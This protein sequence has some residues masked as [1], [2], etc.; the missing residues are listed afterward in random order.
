MDY[1]RKLTSALLILA[2]VLSML[3]TGMLSPTAHAA[4]DMT[5]SVTGQHT[6][7]LYED[8]TS[9]TVVVPP[10]LFS[11][12]P[13]ADA[14]YLTSLEEMGAVL[15]DAMEARDDAPVIYFTSQRV[16]DDKEKLT[17]F[18][19]D[20]LL[21]I[22]FAHTGVSTE[23]DYLRWQ[24]QNMGFGLSGKYKD[25]A[26][27]YTLTFSITYYTTAEQ[28]QTVTAEI[29][30]LLNQLDVDDASDYRK[31]CAIYDYIC[32]NV[33]YDHANL[34]NN[35]Y[36]LK[37]TCYAALI[38]GIAVCQGYALLLYRLA[39]ELDVDA[40]LIAGD[41]GGPH[42]WNI[43]QLNGLYYNLDST[44]DAGATKYDYFLVCPNNFRDHIRYE[45]YDTAE[46]H[47]AYPMDSKDFDPANDVCNHKYSSAIAQEATCTETGVATY[48]CSRCGDSYTETVAALGHEEVTDE[49]F[50]ATCTED[51]LTEGSH[52]GRCDI[53]L[54]EQETIP[55]LGH[56]EVTDKG[57]DATCTEDGRTD[58]SHCSRCDIV[59]TEQKAI[60]A[61]GHSWDEGTVTREPT[62]TEA[63]IRTFTCETCGE[64]REETIPT[65]EHEH[66][67]TAVV[68][69]PTC[70]E[71]GFTTYTCACGDS[72][73]ADEVPALG[74]EEV[75]DK[76]FDA[77][78][79]EDGMTDGSHCSRCDIVLTEQET[80]PALGH[81]WDEGT[82]IREPTETE[83]GIRT[84]TCETCGETKTEEIPCIDAPNVERIAGHD[85]VETAI[86]TAN[87]LKETLN[88][89]AFDTII[90]A[91][92]D[93]F[94]DALAGSYLATVKDAP[95]LLHR[96][97][98]VGDELN[99]DYILN[100][101]TEGGVVYVLGGTAAI[102]ASLVTDLTD[103]GIQ[104]IRLFGDSRFLTNLAILE[105]AGVENQE[106]LITTGWEFADCLSASATGKPI[107][108]LNTVTNE[109][110]AEQVE[111]L[112]KYAANNY[113]I[114][115]G[116]AAVSDELEA[117]IDEIVTGEIV[118][119][120][121]SSREETSVLVAERFFN[122]PKFAVLA[123]SRNFPDGL[124][125]G[126]L[127]YA[128]N[129]P[130]LLTNTGMEEVTAAY[131]AE[132]EIQAGYIMGG[133]GVVSDASVE[134]IFG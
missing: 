131:I 43:A 95:I 103:T 104:V 55:A 92:G 99:Q 85:R 129:A 34:D 109:L 87:A 133:T 37:Y 75:A 112:T 19:V 20:E 26:Y 117:A 53:V 17:S 94:A 121:G 124:C 44:W 31:L 101:L 80:I 54:T 105:E 113:T 66:S 68:T 106:I 4:D 21:P 70:T 126:P 59:L 48:T 13:A 36:T 7:P 81:T 24:Y 42:G 41:G 18:V 125:G 58:G 98:G 108:M 11:A 10:V 46:F 83:T 72:Y 111:F 30:K 100:N 65:L 64:T 128:M 88:K 115:G 77:T 73:T 39:L 51:G 52:C 67:Y 23:G 102:P 69:D 27:Q 35:S 60:P 40:R 123:Y 93:V 50:A 9:G 114:V 119:L 107:L 122:A 71:A 61:L 33:T 5:I 12:A 79:T 91:N 118:R 32:A 97:S 63:G 38:D 110:T 84:F 14:V 132:N 1:I 116:N 134:V 130:L 15:R 2:M 127:A 76:G 62:E 89:D 8:V 6:N 49:G 47:Q 90:L 74:H 45:E 3:G 82:V 22:A 29:D 96:N 120:S 16:I 56:E 78:C 57:F 25:D 28:E 86:K